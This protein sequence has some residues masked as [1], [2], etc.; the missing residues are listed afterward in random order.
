L[1]KSDDGSNN[2]ALGYQSGAYIANGS[3]ELVNVSNSVFIGADT[4]ALI[5]GSDN[6]IVI[7]YNATG[8]G[9]NTAVI[10]NNS[11]SGVYFGSS[12]PSARLYAKGLTLSAGTAT[13]GTAPL[14]L[15]SGTALTTTEAGAIEFHNSHLYFTATNGG[16]RYQLDQQPLS[17]NADYNTLGGTNAGLNLVSGAY[18]NTFLGY[19]AGKSAASGGTNA[20]D[21]NTAVGSYSLFSNTTGHS[22]TANGYQSLYFNTTGYRNATNG[23]QSLY[24]NTIGYSNTANGY[25]SLYSNTTGS[26]NTATG[27]GSL[28]SNTTGYENIATGHYSLYSNTIGGKNTANGISSLSS[29]TAGNNNTANGYYALHSI[30]WPQSAGSLITGF[31]YVIKTTE[32]TNFMVCGASDNNIGTFFTHNGT[33]CTGTGTANSVSNNNVAEGY[34]SGRYISN[35]STVLTASSSSIFLGSRTKALVDGSTNE[36]V[37]GYNTIG[38]GSN[39]TTIGTGNVLYVG[40]SSITGKVARFTNTAGYCDIDPI[41]TSLSC[42]SDISLKKNITTLEQT[43]DGEQV[44]FELNEEIELPSTTLE[45]ILTLTPVTYNWNT[46]E[47]EVDENGKDNKH[48]G[49][50]AQEMEQLFPDLVFTDE[51]RINPLTGEGLKSIAYSNLIPYTIKA[52]Q[53]MNLKVEGINEFELDKNGNTIANS[54]RDSIVAWLGN[55]TNKITRIFT[56]EICLMEEGDE[57]PVCIN[58]SELRELKEVINDGDGAPMVPKVED[59]DAE[60]VCPDDMDGIQSADDYELVEGVCTKIEVSVGG[61]GSV[62][63]AVSSDPV[64]PL[65]PP[66]VVP[67]DDGVG[68]GDGTEVGG[69]E[70]AGEGEGDDPVDGSGAQG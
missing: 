31:S 68:D 14:K 15:T 20:A 35:G 21:Y 24:S 9:S 11:L 48:I 5:D 61:E 7:G 19:E 10:G 66:A 1:N 39:T 30:G 26:S 25:H 8:A 18:F 56:G 2:T 70:G 41:T 53:E 63:K 49:F 12:T 47:Y 16:I 33:P 23:Y 4:K 6:E 40:G 27:Y 17:S 65:V 28:Y 46:E 60:D 69:G 32:S 13:T 67:G 37:I 54:F 22:N 43:P 52:L 34:E 59:G 38:N 44:K 45:K 42:S 57:E 51:D 58:A 3:T 29:N 36:I 64:A 50:I 62:D 55:A